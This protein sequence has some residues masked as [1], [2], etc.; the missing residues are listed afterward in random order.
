MATKNNPPPK[1][2]DV[3]LATK[4]DAFAQAIVAGG[5]GGRKPKPTREEEDDD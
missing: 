4:L 5:G 1:K 3:E 2:Q